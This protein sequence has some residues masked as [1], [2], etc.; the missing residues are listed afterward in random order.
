[1]LSVLLFSATG[2]A[3]YFVCRI[4]VNGDY[5][6]NHADYR[7]RATSVTVGDFTCSGIMKNREVTATISS[8]RYY[9]VVAEETGILF[10]RVEFLDTSF[11][12]EPLDNVYCECGLN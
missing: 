5:R 10:S 7:G 3:D 12:G 1:M 2:F 4:N 9:G 6:E 11:K 8:V